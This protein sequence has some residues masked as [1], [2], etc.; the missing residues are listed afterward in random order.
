MGS[1]DDNCFTWLTLMIV[2]LFVVFTLGIALNISVVALILNAVISVVTEL[3]LM[4]IAYF[5][6]ER[7]V[8]YLLLVFFGILLS[9]GCCYMARYIVGVAV[10]T[11]IVLYIV[12]I[13]KIMYIFKCT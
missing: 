8:P 7:T 9:I 12:S 2:T 4:H 6:V 1:N 3:T 5:C 10:A 13:I 11:V